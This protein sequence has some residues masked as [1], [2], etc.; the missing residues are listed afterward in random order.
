M[1]SDERFSLAD[2]RA[3]CGN[4]LARITIEYAL[5]RDHAARVSLIERALKLIASEF[6][7][8]RSQ[9]QDRSEDELTTDLVFSLKGMGMAASH[10]TDVNG[11]CD[12][13]IEA[14]DDFLWLGE[15]KI[16]SSYDWLLKGFRQLHTR[17]S[18]GLPGQN[19]GGML[20]YFYNKDVKT[21]MD[22]WKSYL[23]SEEPSVNITTI[24]ALTFD[25][26]QTH[27]SSGLPYRARHVPFVL[28]Y[29]P[30]DT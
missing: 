20:I 12:V 27:Q 13:T 7:K 3:A 25:S 30:K 28:Y 9:R 15:A 8:T 6:A 11:H 17:Y 29:S 21:I 1:S 14:R 4:D 22:K 16:H 10:D 2:L 19:C 5:I 23:Q 24:D 18:T 26:E